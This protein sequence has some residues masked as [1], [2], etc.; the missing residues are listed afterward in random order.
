MKARVH[1]TLKNGVLDPQGKAIGHSLNRLGFPEVGDVRQGVEIA[2][3]PD[4]VHE[5]DIRR[6]SV[7]K[8]ARSRQRQLV[9]GRPALDVRAM[10]V[11][12]LVRRDDQPRVGYL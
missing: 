2:Q 4:A 9:R 7:R 3:D 12:R 6:P 10:R 8:R 11:R 1:V 5:H